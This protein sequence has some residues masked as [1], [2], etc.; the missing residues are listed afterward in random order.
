MKL[1]KTFQFEQNVDAIFTAYTDKEFLAKKMEAMG[2]RNIEITIEK[3]KGEIKITSTRE[4][5]ADVPG[6]L[7]K[8]LNPWNKMTQK[9]IWTGSKGGPYYGDLEIKVAGAPVTV[10]G[11]MKIA[12]MHSGS[13]AANSTEISTSIPFLG[14][15]IKK[16]I[17]KA[18]EEA[19]NQEFEYV[20]QNA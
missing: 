16:F 9:E 2:A 7:K 19:I 13:I 15:S 1:T 3:N 10:I 8:F 20:R 6:V 4:M 11:Q 18:S 12:S 14:K 17:A 5:P